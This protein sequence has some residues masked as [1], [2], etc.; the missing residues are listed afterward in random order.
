M[1]YNDPLSSTR[2][3]NIDDVVRMR[4]EIRNRSVHL[5]IYTGSNATP[6]ARYIGFKLTAYDQESCTATFKRLPW[7]QRLCYCPYLIQEEYRH[8]NNMLKALYQ[9]LVVLGGDT[10]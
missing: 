4:C 2:L 8:T 10:F 3:H 1:N 9:A 5:H 6:E 7:Y